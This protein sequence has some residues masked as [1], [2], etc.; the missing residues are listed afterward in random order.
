MY[1]GL[2]LLCISSLATYRKNHFPRIMNSDLPLLPKLCYGRS[3][4]IHVC[5][6][7]TSGGK[8][9][10]HKQP[11]VPW[12]ELPGLTESDL[13]QWFLAIWAPYLSPPPPTPHLHLLPIFGILQDKFSTTPPHSCTQPGPWGNLL[14][15]L[16]LT[17]LFARKSEMRKK[18]HLS[19]LGIL[20]WLMPKYNKNSEIW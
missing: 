16:W 13:L 10:F 5:G 11:N 20:R 12:T 1:L 8:P 3:C 2:R 15:R 6:S 7:L 9:F 19:S 17:V 18:G 4:S 14:E